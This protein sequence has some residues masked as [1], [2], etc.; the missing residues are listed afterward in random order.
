MMMMMVISTLG[1]QGQTTMLTGTPSTLKKSVPLLSTSCLYIDDRLRLNMAWWG[2]AVY[3]E[4]ACSSNTRTG[5][6]N[7][8]VN[9]QRGP[10]DR[11]D[12][13]Q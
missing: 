5:H 4:L 8:T 6:Q 2:P 11:Q 13:G 1:A 10:R 12:R 7:V 3:A 9:T